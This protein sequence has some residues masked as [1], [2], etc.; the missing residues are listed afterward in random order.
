MLTNLTKLER[1]KKEPCRDA[2][3]WWFCSVQILGITLTVLCTLSHM[4]HLSP[5]ILQRYTFAYLLN[6]C[7]CQ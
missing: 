2:E 7:Y 5:P 1:R 3:Y 6:F 4:S